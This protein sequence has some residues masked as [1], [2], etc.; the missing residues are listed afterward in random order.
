MSFRF[1]SISLV[2]DGTSVH[3][4]SIENEDEFWEIIHL[5]QNGIL[6]GIDL[7][8]ST[9]PTMNIQ[10]PSFFID[11]SIKRK[12]DKFPSGKYFIETF[13]LIVIF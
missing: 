12:S 8:I 3:I 6:A 10:N 11:Q 5:F 4:P 13:R 2:E 1:T 7:F 9:P